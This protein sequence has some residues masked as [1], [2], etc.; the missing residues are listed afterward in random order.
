MFFLAKRPKI[1]QEEIIL[2][3]AVPAD[4]R[5]IIDVANAVGREKHTMSRKCLDI[6]RRMRGALLQG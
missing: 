6:V 4:A 2:R 3:E 5:G 1:S